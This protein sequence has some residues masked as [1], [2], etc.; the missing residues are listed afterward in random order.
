MNSGAHAPY[1]MVWQEADAAA[2]G[3]GTLAGAIRWLGT[4]AIGG[5][6]ALAVGLALMPL[7]NRAI[8]PVR[9]G[10][11]PEKAAEERVV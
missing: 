3:V 9:S 4:A 2:A 11:F 1:E 5:V 7:V 10:L 8:V 6:I